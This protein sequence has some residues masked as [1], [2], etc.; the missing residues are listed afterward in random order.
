MPL[1]EDETEWKNLMVVFATS[2]GNVRKN[3]LEDFININNSG[4]IAMKLDQ[5]D[6]I[7]GVKIC[8][9]DQDILLSSQFGKCIRFKS[10]KLR[11]FKG[12]SSKGIKGIKLNDN[13]KVISLSILD[14]INSSKT[15]KKDSKTIVDGYILSVSENGFGKRSS[16]TDYRV[17]NRGGKGII[18]IINSPRNGNIS[19]SL[20]VKN[21]DEIILSTGKGSIM[22]CAVKEIRIAGRNTQGVRIKKLSGNEKVVSV[23]KI[24][25]NIQ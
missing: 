20:F 22:R 25:D 12:R 23:I 16:F 1:P 17:T 2:K 7:I 19:A 5:D 18:G 9:D 4:K 3:T 11:L 14:T 15:V 13:D 6:K 8:K 10:K 24:E 21:D